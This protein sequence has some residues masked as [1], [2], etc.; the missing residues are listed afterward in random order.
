M[1]TPRN[2][3][4]CVLLLALVISACSKKSTPTAIIPSTSAND[5]G[6]ANPAS[7]NCEDKGGILSLQDRVGLGT[8]GVCK[9]DETH[10]CEEWALYRG[11]CPEGG[12][13]VSGY[14]TDA[15]VFCAISGGE[16]AVTGNNGAAEEQ[17]TCTL[18]NGT[19][20]DVWKFYDGTCNAVQ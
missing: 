10:Q 4:I 12:V 13:D 6:L 11:E 3:L 1:G 9:F 18:K 8:I 20:C 17:G 2:L 19:V 7:V 15:A 5:T 14:A 16:Y